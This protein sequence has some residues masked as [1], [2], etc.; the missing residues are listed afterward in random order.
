MTW[1]G[2]V[3][4]W[5]VAPW[6]VSDLV[7]TFAL[8]IVVGL[9][10]L[11]GI[12]LGVKAF[13]ERRGLRARAGSDDASAASIVAAAARELID[14]LR[15]ELAHERAE[16]AGEIEDERAKVA[17]VRRELDAAMVDVARLRVMLADALDTVS[18]Y[19]IRVQQL[20]REL[21]NARRGRS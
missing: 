21:E 1:E 4:T 18:Q 15:L 13:L 9:G 3:A 8:P 10:L 14:P 5:V 6:A 2:V 16:H 19:R 17:Q 7:N 12:G 20:E 11:G